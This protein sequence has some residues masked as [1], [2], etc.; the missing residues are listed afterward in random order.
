M[1]LLGSR[2]TCSIDCTVPWSRLIMRP[3]RRLCTNIW[4][5]K[6]WAWVRVVPTKQALGG[7]IDNVKQG[8]S[9][10]NKLSNFHGSKNR[11]QSEADHKA[12]QRCQIARTKDE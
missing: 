9:Q 11:E 6:V 5:E 10:N 3:S 7:G 8:Y 4:G 2:N 12:R 1:L